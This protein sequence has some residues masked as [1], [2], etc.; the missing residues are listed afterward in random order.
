M[1]ANMGT[2]VSLPVETTGGTDNVIEIQ[3]NEIE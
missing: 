2:I 1:S 3:Q